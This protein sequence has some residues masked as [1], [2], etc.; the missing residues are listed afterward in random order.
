MDTKELIKQISSGDSV[1]AKNT[2]DKLLSLMAFEAIDARKQEVAKNMFGE[3][4]ITEASLTSGKRLISKH[5]DGQHTAKVYHDKEDA[6]NTAESEL[7]RM[8]SK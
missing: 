1:E 2:I 4:T 6:Q 3:E 7:K 8:N 5:G